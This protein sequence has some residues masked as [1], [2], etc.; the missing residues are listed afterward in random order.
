[1]EYNHNC[2]VPGKIH[3]EYFYIFEQFY[4]VFEDISEEDDDEEED[5]PLDLLSSFPN[6]ECS[7]TSP[8]NHA[9]VRRWRQRIAWNDE[10]VAKDNLLMT[11]SATG[12]SPISVK[13]PSVTDLSGP[14]S[15]PS[16]IQWGTGTRQFSPVASS[17]AM[18]TESKKMSFDISSIMTYFS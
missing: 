10:I 4:L 1:M 2:Y 6:G 8:G 14:S 5:V 9:T 15:A 3:F 18:A 12:L 16:I 7:R 17:K 11:H 13:T